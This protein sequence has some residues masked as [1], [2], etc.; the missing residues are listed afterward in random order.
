MKRIVVIEKWC[1]L[2]IIG[3]K[4]NESDDQNTKINIIMID[5]LHIKS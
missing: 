5:N 4:R 1:V 3:W 2:N